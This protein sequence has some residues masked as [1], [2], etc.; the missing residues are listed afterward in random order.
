MRICTELRNW[1]WKMLCLPSSSRMEIKDYLWKNRVSF[2]LDICNCWQTQTLCS[3]H[4]YQNKK[5]EVLS[6]AYVEI[7]WGIINS[8]WLKGGQFTGI[9][10]QIEIMCLGQKAMRNLI[11][12]YLVEY[13][14]VELADIYTFHGMDHQILNLRRT[15]NSFFC[16][17]IILILCSMKNQRGSLLSWSDYGDIH[18]LSIFHSLPE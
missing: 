1:S 2:L 18:F 3:I 14:Y 10:S 16:Y 6:P 17:Y 13:T 15:M 4:G 7:K 8:N 9:W 5:T 12:P 11:K